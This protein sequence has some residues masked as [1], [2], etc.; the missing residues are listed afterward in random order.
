MA[1][2][3]IHKA[4]AKGHV[5]NALVLLAFFGATAPGAHA[6][7]RAAKPSE[8]PASVVAR[9]ALSG[10]PAGQMYLQ[11]NGD[12]QYL[13]IGAN[14]KEGLMVVDVTNPTQPNIIKRLAWP[15]GRSTGKLQMVGD[16]IA[17]AKAPENDGAAVTDASPTETVSLLDLSDPTNP[18]TIQSFSGVTGTLVDD[19]RNLVYITNNDGLWILKHPPAQTAF[20]KPRGCLTEDA[21]NEFANCQ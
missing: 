20:S 14:S 21:F 5:C 13:Y 1:M 7:H 18:R 17:L 4:I 9:L 6:K 16:G 15:N 11:E 19:A 2:K 10:T 3:L 8:Q 12:K